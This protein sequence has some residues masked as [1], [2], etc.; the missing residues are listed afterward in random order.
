MAKKATNYAGKNARV[1]VQVG[2][3][4][5]S[6]GNGTYTVN[7][8]SVGSPRVSGCGCPGADTFSQVNGR[9][10]CVRCQRPL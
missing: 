6:N 4:I 9:R 7:G 5:K 10:I 1:G 3:N 8:V 2:N